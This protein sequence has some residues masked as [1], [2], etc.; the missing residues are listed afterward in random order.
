ML[1]VAV[2]V[3]IAVLFIKWDGIKAKKTLAES[4]YE[5]LTATL[6]EEKISVGDSETALLMVKAGAVDGIELEEA[7]KLY[8]TALEQEDILLLDGMKS[9]LK[10]ANQEVVSTQL[11]PLIE[12]RRFSSSAWL[13]SQGASQ[14]LEMS[15][16]VSPIDWS[17]AQYDKESTKNLM[18][19]GFPLTEKEG[20]VSSLQQALEKQCQEDLIAEMIEY[21]ANQNSFSST[22][23]PL[24]HYALQNS[25]DE[26]VAAM[27]TADT[28]LNIVNS[29]G[30]PAFVK[31]LQ[32]GS[33][34]KVRSLGEAG[35]DLTYLNSAGGNYLDT[36]A[37]AG[38]FPA[39]TGYLLTKGLDSNTKNKQGFNALEQACKEG[40]PQSAGIMIENGATV[41][42]DFFANNYA[43]GNEVALASLFATGL[44]SPDKVLSSGDTLLIDSIKS[45]R[46]EMVQFLCEQKANP[47]LAATDLEPPLAYAI[48]LQ[49]VESAKYLLES[50]AAAQF[51]FQ[52]KVA[53]RYSELI[54]STGVIKWFMTR[55]SRITGIMMACDQGNL[56]MCKL[57]KEHG[58]KESS[59]RKN[60]FWAGNF[61]ARQSHT[62]V[63]QLMLGAIPGDRNRTVT[64]DL[65]Q[66]RATVYNKDKKTVMSFRISSGKK[67]KRTRTGEFVVT[68]K[69][70]HHIST[71]YDVDLPYFQ[72]LSYSDFG[73]HTGVVPGYPASSGCLRCPSSYSK[74]LYYHLKVGDVVTIQQ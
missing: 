71:I 20:Q 56:A 39:V 22:N 24:L 18:K 30:E 12:A 31:A 55:D 48:A 3:A 53:E 50:G 15:K 64:V 38:D 60:R 17:I 49:D 59:T 21:G 11:K 9:K 54:D 36:V 14:D 42:E 13:V 47:N 16:G 68:N 37:R 58:A 2:L 33:V 23:E 51:T 8:L 57:L 4:G 44:I 74:K 73:F 34:A 63:V 62:D 25:T 35:A 45:G 52:D 5:E 40:S 43:A 1:I 6:V 72:R 28:D 26:V 66:Q 27:V 46:K 10:A 41:A 19:L 67:G 69:K 61:A 29:L 7:E 65:S 32:S 70:R